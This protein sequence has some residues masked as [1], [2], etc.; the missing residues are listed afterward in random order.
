MSDPNNKTNKVL[1][2]ITLLMCVGTSGLV[3]QSSSTR[4]PLVSASETEIVSKEAAEELP[5]TAISETEELSQENS[6][7]P[8]EVPVETEVPEEE[9][10]IP[11]DTPV[12]TETEA[13][14]QEAAKADS[15]TV[16][17]EAAQ[18]TWSTTDGIW[19]FIVDNAAY[20][21]W[22]YDSDG[23]VYYFDATDGSMKTGWQD[24]DGKRYYFNLDGVMQTGDI[25]VDGQSY[26][27][28]ADGSLG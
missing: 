24:I 5:E 11:T 12:P 15:Y 7:L 27:M 26:H 13:P 20:H 23:H 1:L 19:Y 28:N 3:T 14:A 9:T 16:S 25:L 10:P 4:S 2:V 8:E 22:L 17:P 18:G 21:G 6:T